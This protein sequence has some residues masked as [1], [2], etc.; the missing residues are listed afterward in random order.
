MGRCF[1]STTGELACAG[2]DPGRPA[3]PRKIS[4]SKDIFQTRSNPFWRSS[5][6]SLAGSGTSCPVPALH[7]GPSFSPDSGR[8]GYSAL[9]QHG[10]AVAAPPTPLSKN[11]RGRC[12][13][14]AL[15]VSNHSG[16][17]GALLWDWTRRPIH[18]SGTAGDL[19]CPKLMLTPTNYRWTNSTRWKR[20]FDDPIPLPDGSELTTLRDRVSEARAHPRRGYRQKCG[21][22]VPL[23][24][25]KSMGERFRAPQ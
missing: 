2:L 3:L 21:T 5:R 15:C 24:R 6:S 25:L 4:L 12:P 10:T 17:G 14:A 16:C 13:A 23:R 11:R 8:P 9:E 22:S 19:Q 18:S 7:I 1:V 20:A